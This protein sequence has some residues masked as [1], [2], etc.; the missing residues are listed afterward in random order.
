MGCRELV[1]Q[2]ASKIIPGILNDVGDWVEATR[3]KSVQLLFVMIWQAEA[4][5]TM[6]LETVLQTLYKA[7]QEKLEVIQSQVGECA[8]LL[9]YFTDP[10]LSLNFAIKNI[11]KMNSLHFGAVNILNSLLSGHGSRVPIGLLLESMRLLNEISITVDVSLIL[12]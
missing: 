1:R 2:N 11:R 9:G 7:S 12:T 5:I 10:I 6:T 3:V 8:R 4:N